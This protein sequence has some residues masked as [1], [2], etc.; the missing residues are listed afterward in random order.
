MRVM[1]VLSVGGGNFGTLLGLGASH[2]RLAVITQGVAAGERLEKLLVEHGKEGIDALW[3]ME[4]KIAKVGNQKLAELAH[5]KD[6]K[7]QQLAQLEERW[8]LYGWLVDLADQKWMEE[9]DFPHLPCKARQ[10]LPVPPARC[11]VRAF[12]IMHWMCRA[13][14]Y[15]PLCFWR[16]SAGGK[17]C[18]P[19]RL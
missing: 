15:V 3:R 18:R 9:K 7:L 13:P 4:E 10:A 8:V 2:Y 1:S 6:E 17:G 11:G 5:Y 12:L 14:L 19:G 16:R